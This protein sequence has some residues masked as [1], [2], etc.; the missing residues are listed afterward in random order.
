MESGLYGRR[1]RGGVSDRRTESQGLCGEKRQTET[2]HADRRT[3]K[4]KKKNKK[5]EEKE[6]EENFHRCATFLHATLQ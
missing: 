2:N 6:E 1:K 4:G 5:K 3:R